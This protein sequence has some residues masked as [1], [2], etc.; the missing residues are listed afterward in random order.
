MKK[1]QLKLIYGSSTLRKYLK[2]QHVLKFSKKLNILSQ[3]HR[4]IKFG[5]DLQNYRIHQLNYETN[6]LEREHA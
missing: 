5:T 1:S 2:I 3:N 4:I 6:A